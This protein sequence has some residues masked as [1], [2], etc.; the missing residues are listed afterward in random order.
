MNYAKL[1]RDFDNFV[2]ENYGIDYMNNNE[3]LGLPVETLKTLSERT[4][5]H[6]D[7]LIEELGMHKSIIKEGKAPD[8]EVKSALGNYVKLNSAKPIEYINRGNFYIFIGIL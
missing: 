4:E 6:D 2:K 5:A 3:S 8:V 7:K 1:N